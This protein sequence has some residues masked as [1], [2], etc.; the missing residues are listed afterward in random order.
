MLAAANRS[1]WA[2]NRLPER[3]AAES[4]KR[5]DIRSEAELLLMHVL[6]VN[7]TWLYAH[8]DDA[9][10]G[11]SADRFRGL[12][13]RRVAGEPIAY[14]TGH[15]EFFALDL[16]VTRDVLIPRAETE[17]LVELALAKIPQHLTVDIADLG[18]GSGAVA[19]ALAHG[20]PQA[21]VLATDAS[22][23]ALAVARANAQRLKISNVQFAQGDWC[24]PLAGK[25]FALIVSNPPYIAA[26]DA[27]LGQG[28]LRF[29]PVAA[30][31]SGTDG[32]DAIRQIAQ[33]TPEHLQSGGWLLLEHG[34]DQGAA[35]R[36]I[37]QARGFVAVETARDLEGRDRVCIARYHV[38]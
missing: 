14:L 7:R 18:T 26:N 9:V 34:F 15:R 30:L 17:L 28:D 35:V 31:A 3:S 5:N 13:E 36:S 4:E 29:E 2:G 8:S 12:M 6:G 1:L 27:H 22:G 10:E 33:T 38:R 16:Q 23:S 21:R 24:A 19:L 25:M 11:E 37:L 20:R 32:L